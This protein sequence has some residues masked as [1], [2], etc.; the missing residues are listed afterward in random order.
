MYSM[1][2][3]GIH[4]N[5]RME[6]FKMKLYVGNLPFSVDDSKLKEAFSSFGDVEEASVIKDKFSGRSKGFGFVTIKDDEAAKK[7]ISE[8]NGKNFEG[9]EM[10]VSESKPRDESERPRRSFGSD[11]GNYGGFNGGRRSGGFGRR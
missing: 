6:E 10:K 3:N 2:L 11:R 5:V 4:N 9:R 8:M 7:A 1:N